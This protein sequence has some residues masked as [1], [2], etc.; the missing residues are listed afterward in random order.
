MSWPRGW[1]EPGYDFP[2]RA[3]GP[4]AARREAIRL[5]ISYGVAAARR[6]TRAAA[7]LARRL[8]RLKAYVAQRGWLVHTRLQD[9]DE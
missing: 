3:S 9:D 7:Y 6:D 5:R 4:E 1:R 8:T 2:Q